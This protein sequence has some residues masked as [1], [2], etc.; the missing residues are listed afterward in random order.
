M[1]CPQTQRQRP[2]FTWQLMALNFMSTTG[3]TSTPDCRR[4]SDWSPRSIHPRKMKNG[5]ERIEKRPW[6]GL[7]KA[8]RE[9]QASAIIWSLLSWSF[10]LQCSC[11]HF[12]WYKN[13]FFVN[14]PLNKSVQKTKLQRSRHQQFLIRH[15]WWLKVHSAAPCSVFYH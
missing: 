7:T 11:L 5:D 15:D 14:C 10:L 8:I 3:P 1:S 9:N 12:G 13:V 6:K 2:G 4:P